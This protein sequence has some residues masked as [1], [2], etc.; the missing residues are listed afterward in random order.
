MKSIFAS[1]T[2]WANVL[3]LAA[4]IAGVLPPKYAAVV[5]PLVNVL[6]RF[7]TDSEVTLTGK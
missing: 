1:K 5:M 6:L 4:V 2:F 3:A 7:V